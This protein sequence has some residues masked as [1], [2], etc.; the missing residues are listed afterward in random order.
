MGLLA[1]ELR[2]IVHVVRPQREMENSDLPVCLCKIK[3]C[4]FSLQ[5][6]SA[7]CTAA[8]IFALPPSATGL[9]VDVHSWN[10]SQVVKYF[11]STSDCKEYASV[12]REQEIDGTAL[13]LLTHESLVKCLSIK[14][15]RA[16][17][18]MVHVEELQRL[19]SE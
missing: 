3:N 7:M 18:I 19:Y 1:T 6:I 5:V 2:C 4:P 11:E 12:F 8:A 10:T 13:L 15:G 9:P 17:K 16:L 14:L